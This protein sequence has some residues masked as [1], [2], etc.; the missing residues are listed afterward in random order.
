MV[1]DESRAGAEPV[2]GPGS[3][4]P[5]DETARLLVDLMSPTG[6]D[7]AVVFGLI[8][9]GSLGVLGQHGYAPDT[10]SSWRRIPLTLDVPLTRAINEGLPVFV[11]SAEELGDQFPTLRQRHSV[12]QA[13]A[14][15]PVWDGDTRIGCMGFSWTDEQGFDDAQRQR[16]LT[17]AR[18]AST[19]I[20]RNLRAADPD[21]DYL[22]NVLHLLRDPWLVMVPTDDL[23]VA[24]LVVESVS[25]GVKGGDDLVG[26][27]L[28]VA[29]PGVAGDT[30]LLEELQRLLR[31]GGRFVRGTQS[32]G[33][34]TAP[35]DRRAGRL[36]AVRA[37]R[38]V[39]LTWHSLDQ[40]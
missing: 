40:D 6:V 7:A 15:V 19:V 14:V 2:A 39:A 29:F 16:V 36:R 17:V 25:A 11:G 28:L 30:R 12:H 34:T 9:D 35:W 3:G 32:A 5:G 13:L 27:R 24:S 31:Y 1:T 21:H 20:M 26:A 18:R 33:M 8:G 23:Q 37:G 4:L 10:V 38:R 22:T